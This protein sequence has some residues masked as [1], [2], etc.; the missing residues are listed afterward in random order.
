MKKLQLSPSIQDTKL[1]SIA[2][3]VDEDTILARLRDLNQDYRE[4]YFPL[5]VVSKG[6]VALKEDTPK[7]TNFL[8]SHVKSLLRNL[9]EQQMVDEID[10][11]VEGTRHRKS[12][13]TH[14]GYYEEPK[15]LKGYRV[16][17]KA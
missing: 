10:I 6:L 4:S 13:H 9:S 11:I 2:N 1:I 16:T 3:S 12:R 17:P 7:Y 5:S 15:R 8:E 14:S